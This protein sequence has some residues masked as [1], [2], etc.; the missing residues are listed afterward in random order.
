M[1][2]SRVLQY[3]QN[4]CS[5]HLLDAVD[6]AAPRTQRGH[7]FRAGGPHAAE[8]G[9]AV[10]LFNVDH[11]QLY[12]IVRR[13]MPRN[14]NAKRGSPSTSP[15]AFQGGGAKGDVPVPVQ[16]CLLPAITNATTCATPTL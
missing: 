8:R 4:A 1:S 6:P 5:D 12:E 10:L 7:A 2:T 14:I 13:K 3:L 15:V 16:G 9:L 11:N